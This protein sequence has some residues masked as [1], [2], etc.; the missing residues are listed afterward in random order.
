M[1]RLV[2]HLLNYGSREWG[3]TLN[4]NPYILSLRVQ[5][6]KNNE[7]FSCQGHLRVWYLGP[8]ALIL[9]YLDSRYALNWVQGGGGSTKCS[10]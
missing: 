4:P 6:P 8:K 9:G 3:F 1:S 5:V 7:G 2:S 10:T